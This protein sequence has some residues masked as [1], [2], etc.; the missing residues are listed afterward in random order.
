MGIWK[1]TIEETNE[2]E[3]YLAM[4]E[5]DW[6]FNITDI[7]EPAFSAGITFETAEEA[8]LFAES[9]GV[10]ASLWTDDHI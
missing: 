8:R 6:D 2:G 9:H 7:D 5:F 4:T 3:F 10:R 1:T